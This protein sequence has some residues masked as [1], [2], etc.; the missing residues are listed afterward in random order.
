MV[1]TH[2]ISNIPGSILKPRANLH[3][4]PLMRTVI[5]WLILALLSTT[6]PRSWWRAYFLDHPHLAVK[7]QRA[8]ANPAK[9]DKPKAFCH[10]CLNNI[11]AVC[12]QQQ[13]RE[14]AQNVRHA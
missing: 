6:A 2:L 11:V 12:V 4:S 5:F 3:I 14:V 7:G 8:Y 10:W 13:Q 9:H 1:S